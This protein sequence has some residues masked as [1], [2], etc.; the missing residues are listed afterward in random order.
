MSTILSHIERRT[1]KLTASELGLTTSLVGAGTLIT[2]I[3]IL[4]AGWSVIN[5]EVRRDGTITSAA[6]TTVVDIGVTGNED[7][8]VDGVDVEGAAGWV[9]GPTFVRYDSTGPVAIVAQV[10]TATAA[11]TAVAGLTIS[12]DI[13]KIEEEN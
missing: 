8:I 11:P 13:V 10:I 2:L 9:T 7:A 3:E 6:G 12:L 4:P 5:V 1:R